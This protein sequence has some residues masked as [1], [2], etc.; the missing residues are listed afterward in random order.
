MDGTVG[1]DAAAG[2]NHGPDHN[3]LWAMM[4]WWAMMGLG[5]HDGVWG[6]DRLGQWWAVDHDGLWM[7]PWWGCGAMMGLQGHDG[8]RAMVGCGRCHDGSAC[9]GGLWGHGEAVGP[10][11]AVSVAMVGLRDPD[12]AALS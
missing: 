9:H 11:W 3:R 12:V 7:V 4:G 8:P 5:G 10:W 1:H 2:S 6:H